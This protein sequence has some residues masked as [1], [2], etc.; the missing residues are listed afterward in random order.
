[1]CCLLDPGNLIY[2]QAL[3]R[4]QRARFQNNLRG[5]PLAWLTTWPIKARV[6]AAR[7]AKDYRKVLEYGERVLVPNPWDVPTQ[8]AMAEAMDALGLLDMAIWCLEQAR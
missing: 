3:R 1:K 7:R 5:S 6:K 2:R 8:M 4:T